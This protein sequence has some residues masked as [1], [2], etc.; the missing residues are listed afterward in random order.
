M[1][2]ALLAN[3]DA[4]RRVQIEVDKAFGTGRRPWPGIAWNRALMCPLR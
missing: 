3:P 4:Q 1:I 2:Y